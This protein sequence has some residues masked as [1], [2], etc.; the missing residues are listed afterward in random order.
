[1]SLW[2]S[3]SVVAPQLREVWELTTGQE[4]ALTLVVQLGFVVGALISAVLNLADTI[5]SRR[6]F[7]FSALGGAGANLAL[8]SVDSSSVSF[9]LALRFATGVFLA[10]VYPAGLKVM[11][12]WF[13][14][15][16]GMALGV[17]VGA[18]AV[19]SA[20]LHLVRSWGSIGVAS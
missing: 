5:P 13:T 20:S 11:A 8:L 2:F 15:G 6:L 3:A 19:G 1:M 17:L 9:G 7:L 10:G 18:L 12:G 14:A 4:A 16:R